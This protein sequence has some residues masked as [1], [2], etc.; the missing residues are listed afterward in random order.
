MIV[1]IPEYIIG[2]DILKGIT[3]QLSD[4]QYQFGIKPYISARP[5]L[6]GKIRMPPVQILPATKVV[7]I[8]Q[9]R[10]PGGHEEI[11]QMI[12][13]LLEIGVLKP[14]TTAWNN[15]VWPVK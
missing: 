5:V 2:I 4:G 11:S 6:V 10:I 8:K 3:L 9:Y 14:T 13:D 12:K 1:P 15:S 7:T